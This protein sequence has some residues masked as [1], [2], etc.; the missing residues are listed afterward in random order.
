M[1]G[2]HFRRELAAG[3]A[4]IGDQPVA[5]L[6]E[7]R[8]RHACIV[9]RRFAGHQA[10]LGQRSQH[11]GDTRRRD[12]E[13]VSEVD[14]PQFALGRLVERGQQVK[15]AEAQAVQATEH[16]VEPAARHRMGAREGEEKGEGRLGHDAHDTRVLN[17]IL[18]YS[19]VCACS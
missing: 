3:D 6:G 7:H 14:P 11:P 9:A 15:V 4:G 16:G 13:L 2:E 17:K 19:C 5:C 1:L 10:P 12:A 8:E 18:E